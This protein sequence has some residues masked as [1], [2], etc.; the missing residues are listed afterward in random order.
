MFATEGRLCLT[1]ADRQP[2]NSNK[3]HQAAHRERGVQWADAGL[4]RH[5]ARHGTVHFVGEEPLGAHGEE[6]QH[7]VQMAHQIHVAGQLKR[8]KDGGAAVGV[9]DFS[10][11]IGK[12]ML[13]VQI[14][15]P[16]NAW[17]TRDLGH[18]GFPPPWS[19]PLC[20][21]LPSA[22]SRPREQQP[23]NLPPFVALSS[24]STTLPSP[25]TWMDG[26]SARQAEYAVPMADQQ[27]DG[28]PLQQS[29]R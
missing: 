12:H 13:Q 16:L 11:H 17:W 26:R 22:R 1:A 3:Q 27:V 15:R 10:R 5:Q 19:S 7:T 18:A 2:V 25:V 28:A 20:F 23:R 29:P 6:A 9:E 24:R 21:V 8:L 4:L 14:H